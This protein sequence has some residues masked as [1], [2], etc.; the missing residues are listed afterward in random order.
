QFESV[1]IKHVYRDQNAQADALCNEAM[2]DRAPVAHASHKA[3]PKP[4]RSESGSTVEFKVTPLMQALDLMKES[5]IEW[6]KH[7]NPNDPPPV[8]VLNRIVEILQR[9]KAPAEPRA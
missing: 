1:V 7:G 8:E 3:V 4:A 6:A 9:D 5:A 2:D